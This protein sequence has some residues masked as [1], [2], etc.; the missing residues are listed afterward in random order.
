MDKTKKKTRDFKPNI[1]FSIFL[2]IGLV[3]GYFLTYRT[4]SGLI[5]SKSWVEVPCRITSASVGSHTSHDK[6]RT[7]TTY[8]ID[9][10]YSYGYDGA[11]YHGD[12]YDFLGGSSSGRSGKQAVVDKYRRAENP[13]CFVNPDKPVQSVLN[14]DVSAKYLL[15]L[16]PFVFIL[17]G[18]FGMANAGKIKELSSKKKGWE[19]AGRG[20]K[21]EFGEIVIGG[22]SKFGSFFAILIFGLIWNGVIAFALTGSI[23]D[24]DYGTIIFLAIFVLIG[25]V[26]I[27][28]MLYSLLALF[29][30]RMTL[31]LSGG[32]AKLGEAVSVKWKLNSGKLERIKS[33]KLSLQGEELVRYQSGK[34]TNTAKYRF[35]DMDFFQTD[36]KYEIMG[37]NAVLILPDDTMHSL[38]LGNKKII[39]TIKLTGEIA[40]WPDI[41][42]EYKIKI[43]P[44]GGSGEQA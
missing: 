20:Q 16:I 17:V 6:G 7:S 25:L 5:S 34:N 21:N 23:K 33:L 35:F 37:G 13:V 42:E 19:Q 12:K 30:P 11:V 40:G 28:F 9:I 26:L 32:E 41:T 36:N 14:R 10:E 24:R 38:D 2:I 18:A 39:W 3:M 4:L 27:V 44:E 1:F 8:S 15:T 22:K 43:L 31:I 29:N